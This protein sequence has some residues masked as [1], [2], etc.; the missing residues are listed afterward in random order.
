M[1]FFARIIVVSEFG[2]SSCIFSS[3]DRGGGRERERDRQREIKDLRVSC[4]FGKVKDL[5]F[6]CRLRGLGFRSCVDRISKI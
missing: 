5:S 4:R 6:S 2:N 3:S 1:E